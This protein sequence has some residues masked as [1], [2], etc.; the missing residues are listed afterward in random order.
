MNLE[1]Q[2]QKIKCLGLAIAG[3]NGK[4]TTASLIERVL[5][6]NDRRTLV[7][8][9][10]DPSLES[11]VARTNDLDFII[12]QFG[13]E[14][15]R[16]LKSYRPA[17]AVL[18]NLAPHPIDSFVTASE[19][20]Q[21]HVPLFANQQFFDWAVVQSQALT[22]LR[23]AGVALSAKTITFSATD[24]SADLVLNR[25]LLVSKLPNWPGPLLDLDYCLLRGPH[26]AENLLATLAVGHVLR[27]PLEDMV[28]SLKTY[29]A[30][31][32]RCQL[33]AEMQGV[34]FIDDSKACNLD[35]ME[36]AL[37]AVRSG[38]NGEPNIWLIAGGMD[39]DLDFHAAGPLLSR[40]VK[41]AFLLGKVSQK[42]R[43]AWGL[44]TPCML[45]TSLLEAVAEAARNAT[46]GD[47]VLLS[48]AC[49]GLDQFRNYQH[50]GQVFC[51][52]VKS[53]G[54]GLMGV[55]PYMHGVSPGAC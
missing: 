31:S 16:S 45:A 21:A 25:G 11:V 52:A 36:N 2:L 43:S 44:F 55:S 17:V 5:R 34:Q 28:D 6:H 40:R 42:I 23:E 48:P 46:S 35:A 24:P 50:R 38:P 14:Q 53:I 12:L 1:S 4:S 41:G 18:L 30:G 49:S 26:N 27:L 32:H 54:R 39:S 19:Y 13:A 37:R 29:F 8:D 10:Q 33:V 7:C 15:I 20:A 51:E 22:K 3:T 47:V 9:S